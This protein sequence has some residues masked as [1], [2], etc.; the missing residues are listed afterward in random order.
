MASM[1][2]RLEALRLNESEAG[3]TQLGVDAQKSSDPY[4]VLAYAKQQLATPNGT[5]DGLKLLKMLAT[6]GLG[7]IVKRPLS[8]AQ[9]LLGNA[10]M[11]GLYGL[12][13]S[14]KKAFHYYLQAA[15][16]MHGE[17]TFQ[18]GKCHEKGIGCKKAA[19]RA[20]EYYRKAA[21]LG[22]PYAMH[23]LALALLF[24]E[25]GQKRNLKEGIS[26][27]KRAAAE[28]G[29]WPAMH[30]LARCYEECPVVIKDEAFARECYRKAAV[31][32]GYG[33]SQFRLGRA[34]EFGQ[35]GLDASMDDAI[36]WYSRAA[37]A[38]Y[39]QAQ[40]AMSYWTL[41][42]IPGALTADPPAAL[43]WAKLAAAGE[44]RPVDAVALYQ[45]A[46]FYEEGVGQES[47]VD[48][49]EAVRLYGQAASLGH[50]KSKARLKTMRSSASK[51]GSHSHCMVQ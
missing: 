31:D 26:W 3:D 28:P 33:P 20:V 24:G 16:Q 9:Y 22:E 35:L 18:V 14:P 2:A 30:D 39:G 29:C 17:A 8:D 19:R 4:V 6:K 1:E 41:K 50:A 49:E 43:A 51:K 46:R 27:L 10:Y 44:D 5:S 15:K 11:D 7:R 25:L 21:V 13:A 12:K 23:R 32:G 40:M 45:L 36:G 47:G 42:G 34:Y 38:G 37:G 48:M